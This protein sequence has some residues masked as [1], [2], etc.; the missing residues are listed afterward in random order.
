MMAVVK[1]NAYGHG[2]VEVAKQSLKSGAETLGVA[3]VDEAVTLRREGIIETPILVFG[4][5]L[6]SEAPRIV[7]HD[8]S[9]VVSNIEIV[10]ALSKEGEKRNRGVKVHVKVDTGMGRVGVPF[11]EAVTFV[12]EVARFSNVELEGLMTHFSTADIPNDL[13]YSHKQLERFLK[14]SLELEKQGVE[15]RWRHAANSGGVVF[16]PESHLDLVRPGLLIYGVPPVPGPCRLSLRP[17]LSLKAKLT[18]VKDVEADESISYGRTFTTKRRSRTGIVPLGYGDGFSRRHSNRGRV[19][20]NGEYSP[21]IGRV[22]MDQFIVDLTDAGETQVG[23]EAVV[24]GEQRG[25]VLTAWD[26]AETMDSIPN[27]VLSALGVRIPRF[28]S[29]A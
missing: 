14:V 8:I 5:S 11:K 13:D 17:A 20:V 4:A 23:D 3:I 7:H 15:F 21:I 22:C 26:V 12:T 27:E 18:Q 19:I 2:L 9:Q 10:R 24:I 16:V 25:L 1:A 29:E 6:P 28:F